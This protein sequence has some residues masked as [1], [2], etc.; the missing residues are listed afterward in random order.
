M[1]GSATTSKD[2][3]SA[4]QRVADRALRFQS[5]VIESLNDTGHEAAAAALGVD[6]STVNRLKNEHLEKLCELLVFL[7]L[8][9]V[10][11]D[12]KCFR[13]QDIDPY[14]QLAKR[15]MESIDGAEALAWGE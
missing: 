6:K 13:A 3:A 1:A 5:L 7:D 8:K 14:I 12:L 15:H 2:A 9:I 11:A 4:A 10:P